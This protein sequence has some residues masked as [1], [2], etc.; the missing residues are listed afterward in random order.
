MHATHPR[1]SA[2]AQTYPTAAFG[3]FDE[4]VEAFMKEPAVAASPPQAAA[5]AVAG[6]VAANRCAM[7][8]LNWIVDGPG[9]EKQH[10]IK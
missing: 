6:A 8:N 4:V 1:S 7:T 10:K 5:L 2:C 9:L 3:T